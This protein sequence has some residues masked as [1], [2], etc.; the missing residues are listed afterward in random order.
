MEQTTK[1]V[2][3]ASPLETLKIMWPGQTILLKTADC[4]A[5]SVRSAIRVLKT[6]GYSFTATEKGLIN[7]IKVTRNR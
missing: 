1:P 6:R 4:K 2:Q 5:S 7:E 3:K